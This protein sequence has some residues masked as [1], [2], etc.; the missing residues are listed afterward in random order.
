[1]LV[2]QSSLSLVTAWSH[3]ASMNFLGLLHYRLEKQVTLA[4]QPHFG[5]HL[6]RRTHQA[7]LQRDTI[8]IYLKYVF[9]LSSVRQG[10]RKG[11]LKYFLRLDVRFGISSK[12]TMQELT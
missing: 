6:H 7:T 10:V 3:K 9:H 5:T 2:R 12:S 1:M 4:G 11:D 8:M